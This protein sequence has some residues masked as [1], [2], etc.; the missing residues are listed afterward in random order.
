MAQSTGSAHDLGTVRRV[1]QL[2]EESEVSCWIFGGWA[3][4][5]RALCPARTH[6]DIDLLCRAAS[7][8]AVDEMLRTRDL[9]E[10]EGKRFHHKRAF[11]FEGV[12]VELFLVQ[13]AGRDFFTSFWGETRHDWPADTFEHVLDLPVVG[14]QALADYRRSHDRLARRRPS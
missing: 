13:R 3:E 12:M 2:L 5:L 10:I 8:S 4:E 1:L 7:F 14:A 6:R 11:L 9:T